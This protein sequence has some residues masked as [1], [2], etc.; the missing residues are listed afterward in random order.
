MKGVNHSL[1]GNEVDFRDI[2]NV[3]PNILIKHY[4]FKKT[5]TQKPKIVMKNKLC[6]PKNNKL[7]I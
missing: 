6:L 7:S 4:N 2:M 3:S 1:L 5:E